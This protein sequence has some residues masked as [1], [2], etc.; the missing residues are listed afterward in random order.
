MYEHKLPLIDL[1]CGVT[2]TQFVMG[3]KWK[4]YLINCITKGHHRPIEFENIIKDAPR[5]VLVQQLGELERVGIV[6]KEIFQ[7]VPMRV[8]YYLTELG[9]TLVPIIRA[10][11]AWGNENA[12]RFDEKGRLK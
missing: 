6:R 8:E 10:M 4:P 2:V 1:E 3:G 12:H 5:R 9:E 7:E 11:D